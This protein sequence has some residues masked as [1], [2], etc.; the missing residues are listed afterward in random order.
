MLVGNK[1]KSVAIKTLVEFAAKTGSLDRKFTP[2]PSA[3]E[4]I[5][6]HRRVTANR[7]K[8]YQTEI[9]LSINY[10]GITFR[11]R[12]DGYDPKKHC[13]E[14]I[15]T[16]YGEFNNIPKNHQ[17]LHWAQ[18]RCYGWMYCEIFGC[19][20]INLTLVYFNL[21]DQ[22]EYLLEESWSAIDL[23]K[24]GGDLAEKYC[25]WQAHIDKR[26]IRLTSWIKQLKFPHGELYDSQRVM[27]EAVYKAAALGRVLLAEAPTGTGKTLAGLFPAIKSMVRTPV[28]KIFYLTAKTT[29]KQLALDNIQ[30]IASDKT[31]LEVSPLRTLE[32]TAKENGR[33]RVI[34]I[35]STDNEVLQQTGNLHHTLI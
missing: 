31:H 29:G 33:N 26:L 10:D 3:Q 35:P 27:A 21:A 7:H 14:E 13:I 6:G 4:G 20:Q 19:D 1:S 34:M 8:T 12:A 9:P 18:V 23:K 15:K 2:S 30:L 22:Q 17:L 32:L 5:Q 24:F 28:D 25:Q 11:G 16:F